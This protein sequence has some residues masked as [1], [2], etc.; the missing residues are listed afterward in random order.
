MKNLFPERFSELIK[1]SK[2]SYDEIA[3]KL[4]IK[5]KGTIS[6]Y[7]NGDIKNPNISMVEQIAN[8]FGVSPSWLIGFTD[9]KYYD[10]KLENDYIKIPIIKGLKNL[11]K[12]PD[13][14]SKSYI[15]VSKTLT[16]N[17]IFLG[18]KITDDSM[19]PPIFNEDIIL[20]EKTSEYKNGDIGLFVINNADI[21]IRQIID[22]DNSIILKP[23]NS[24]FNPI[25][26]SYN[27][28]KSN[29][30]NLIGIVKKIER[31][32]CFE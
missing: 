7:A 5:S 30:V 32:K 31:F 26:Y 16:K 9:N 2:L 27:D 17:N 29:K 24:E 19:Y 6:K 12:L 4:G 23:L 13:Y 21:L 20:V 1:D 15:V 3:K 22:K 8:T 18:Y 28:F 10:E 25:V 14:N 11:L